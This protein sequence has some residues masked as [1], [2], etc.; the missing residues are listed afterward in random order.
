MK[1]VILTAREAEIAELVGIGLSVKAIAD[2]LARRGTHIAPAT[3][4]GHINRIAQKLEN[5][6]HLTPMAAIKHWRGERLAS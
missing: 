2:T 6:Y 4:T 3:V 5:P 1:D